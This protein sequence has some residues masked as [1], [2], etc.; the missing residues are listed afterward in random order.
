MGAVSFRSWT[1][2]NVER[3]MAGNGETSAKD[4]IWTVQPASVAGTMLGAVGAAAERGRSGTE[5]PRE[6]GC[7]SGAAGFLH[8]VFDVLFDRLCGND[9]RVRDFLVRMP[10]GQRA[11]YLM[12]A[13]GEMEPLPRLLGG[14]LSALGNLLHDDED[15]RP[16]GATAIG[17]P[18]GPKEHG[19]IRGAHQAP[20]LHLFPVLR[21]VSDLKRRDDFVA[22]C[23]DNRREHARSHLPVLCPHNLPAQL[24]G[25]PIHMHQLQCWRK[26]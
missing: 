7:T 3:S 25:L 22:Q 5:N 21:I 8:D 6:D 13:G 1:L 14:A 11:D 19:R 9:E 12:L 10:F 17:Q 24:H 16:L 18:E 20:D 23:G 15:P 4:K 26:Q 2:W